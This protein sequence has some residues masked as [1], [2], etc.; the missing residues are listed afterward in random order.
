MRLLQ[1]NTV[2]AAVSVLYAL[3]SFAESSVAA[4]TFGE[5]N[6]EYFS[7]F[8]ELIALS[9]IIVKAEAVA[10][11][12]RDGAS[13]YEYET[14]LRIIS[15]IKGAPA[16]D[17]VLFQH[18]TSSKDEF[19][20]HMPIGGLRAYVHFETGRVYV[21]FAAKTD[22]PGTYKQ[23][24]Q[25]GLL[26]MRNMNQS[27]TVILAANDQPFGNGNSVESIIW[28][29]LTSLL[30]SGITADVIYAIGQYDPGEWVR[31]GWNHTTPF[32]GF[33]REKVLNEIQHLMLSPDAGIAKAAV[34]ETGRESPYIA[35]GWGAYWTPRRINGEC[36]DLMFGPEPPES[37]NQDVQERWRVL[38][39]VANG[40]RGDGPDSGNGTV[41]NAELRSLAIR[42]LGH[43]ELPQ[44]YEHI[45]R[46][47]TDPEPVVRA[48]AA[49]LL[50]DFQCD[51]ASALIA[52]LAADEN[53][54]VREKAALSICFSR[55]PE[56]LQPL[57]GMLADPAPEVR[58][59]AGQSLLAFPFEK[60]MPTLEAYQ[61]DPYYGPDFTNL[62]AAKNPEK[63]LD[64]LSRIIG[65]EKNESVLF[66]LTPDSKS[67]EIYYHY[68]QRQNDERINL[69]EMSGSF[70]LLEDYALKGHPSRVVT[71]VNFYN[72]RGLSARAASL[73]ER[74][75]AILPPRRIKF[76]LDYEKKYGP[77]D[78]GH[79]SK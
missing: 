71:L 45:A 26:S 15:S 30:N 48:A 9:D 25:S 12:H 52:K 5:R 33:S 56:L 58:K 50:N 18:F 49:I 38:C 70:D 21:I 36:F 62:L 41:S 67:W 16:G 66:F 34:Y 55:R 76:F 74:L 51:E 72:V 3:S 44:L 19:R 32:Y 57:I 75:E 40:K 35:D 39:A 69:P 13:K 60:I 63:Y 61:D 4:P 42:A 10:T 1:K 24:E 8:Q 17:R 14:E 64:R 77:T 27:P 73:M 46:W 54:G 28:N 7:T 29:E 43:A 22:V 37:P 23:V 59:T 2:L 20:E 68:I 79:C 53:G 78:W 11:G 65:S 6:L 47:V 31:G